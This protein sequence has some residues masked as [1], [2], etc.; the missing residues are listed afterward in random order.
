MLLVPVK[1]TNKSF[2]LRLIVDQPECKS[3]E[4]QLE[5]SRCWSVYFHPVEDKHT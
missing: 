2:K 5:H 4:Q 3:E 1:G